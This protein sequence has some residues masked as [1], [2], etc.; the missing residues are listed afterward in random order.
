[1]MDEDPNDIYVHGQSLFQHLSAIDDFYIH[2]SAPNTDA[3]L[4]APDI[5][6]HNPGL[7][8]LTMNDAIM[9]E[10]TSDPEVY[11]LSKLRRSGRLANCVEEIA[12]KRW[13]SKPGAHFVNDKEESDEEDEEDIQDDVSV[14]DSDGDEV[15]EGDEDDD[16][17]FAAPTQ[18]GI[19]LWDLLGEGFLKEVSQLGMWFRYYYF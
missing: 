6:M 12:H 3:V 17:L 11:G 4:S 1:M 2:H 5:D 13:G 14:A 8:H 16:E 10:P 18:E 7:S 15:L 19:S 9:E